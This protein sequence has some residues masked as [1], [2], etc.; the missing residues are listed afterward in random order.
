MPTFSP[1]QAISAESTSH[2]LMEA[3]SNAT[4]YPSPEITPTFPP[5]LPLASAVSSVPLPGAYVNHLAMDDGFLYWT[6]AGG[7]RLFRY[8]LSSAK[9]TAGSI[10]A[11][12]HFAQGMLS[13]YPGPAL[14][15]AGN[16]LVFDDRE[17]ADN[18][19]AWSLRRAQCAR[20]I[21]TQN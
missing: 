8:S 4:P 9:N 10:I 21:G 13:G 5:P 11:Q 3:T 7:G 12:T 6:T 17:F 15:R 14:F 2:P 19:Y 16:W 1:P 18:T 20:R